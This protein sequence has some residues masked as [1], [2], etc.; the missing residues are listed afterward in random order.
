M[1]HIW[2]LVLLLSPPALAQESAEPGAP[3]AELALVD[4]EFGV[5]TRQFGLR[6]HVEM[7]QWQ[8]SD[9]EYEVIWSAQP[10]DSS[11]FP[12]RYR[13]PGEFRLPSR[14]WTTAATMPDGRPLAE[15]AV[16]TLGIWRPLT[17][18]PEALPEN[19]AA[20]FQFDGGTLT[21]AEDPNAPRA[22]DLRI[23]WLERVL[24]PLRGQVVLEGGAWVV[25]DPPADSAGTA[26]VPP[27]DGAGEVRNYTPWAGGLL[28]LIIATLVAIRHHRRRRRTP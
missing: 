8:R 13:N 7:A 19:M 16:E 6:R 22:G 28:L 20:T 14:E 26:E 24:P 21:T 5:A 12:P 27:A 17:P 9:G 2:L 4:D 3:R 10:I 1:K 18:V 25:A 15:A 23:R 11:G